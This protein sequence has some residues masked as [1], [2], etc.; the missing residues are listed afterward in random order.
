VRF[1]APVSGSNQPPPDNGDTA[2]H[3]VAGSISALITGGDRVLSKLFD[4]ADPSYDEPIQA[5]EAGGFVF[6][7]GAGFAGQ[8]RQ[9]LRPRIGVF[10][11]KGLW[12]MIPR[13]RPP[14]AAARL[15]QT[16]NTGPGI[17][18]IWGRRVVR[19]PR[20][21]TTYPTISGRDPNA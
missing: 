7:S 14:E 2:A 10:R 11:N 8:E 20:V 6:A 9:E 5:G 4:F 19:S 13:K 1:G 12:Q 15:A 3:S 21:A 18:G 17:P 16:P